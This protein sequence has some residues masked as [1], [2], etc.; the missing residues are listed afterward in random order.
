VNRSDPSESDPLPGDD[1]IPD[2]EVVIDRRTILDAP[3]ERIWPWLVQLGKGRAGWYLT[4]RLERFT[5][6]RNRALRVIDDAYQH[7][8]VGDRVADHGADGWFEA[9]VIDPP[10]ALV[11]WSERSTELH[12]TWA[13]VLEP[14]GSAETELRIRLRFDRH[15]GD[16]APALVQAGAEMFDR[17]TIR[18]M[19]AGLRERISDS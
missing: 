7:V 13:F 1:L 16:R 17:V 10:R 8:S 11:W 15:L 19:I 18:M 3:P 6:T 9:V 12:V 2:A 14:H 4:R 5:P